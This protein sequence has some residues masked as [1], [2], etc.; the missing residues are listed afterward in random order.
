MRPGL[1]HSKHQRVRRLGPGRP[2]VRRHSPAEHPAR[3][4][5]VG[6]SCQSRCQARPGA[7]AAECQTL[8]STHPSHDGSCCPPSHRDWQAVTVGS[9]ALR[10]DS[11]SGY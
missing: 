7:Q 11:E 1:D 4:R 5:P 3:A 10:L 6:A 8:N 9:P 2:R